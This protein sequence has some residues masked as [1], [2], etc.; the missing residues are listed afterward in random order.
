ME[1]LLRRELKSWQK[2][3]KVQHGREPTKRDIL[4]DPGIAGTYDTWM[5]VG[6][7]AKAAKSKSKPA[8]S[9]STDVASSSKERLD[10][11]PTD[12]RPRPSEESQRDQVFKTPSKKRSQ[13]FTDAT[14]PTTS[15]SRNPFRTPTKPSSSTQNSERMS[16]VAV[17]ASRKAR[18]PFA[19][20]SKASATPRSQPS[21]AGSLIEV[22]MTPTRR[23]PLDTFNR[24]NHLTPSES[25]SPH[26]QYVTSSPSKLR[27]AL[28]STEG[29]LRRTPTKNRAQS[30]AALKDALVAYTPRTKA[31]KRLRGEDVPPTPNRRRVSGGMVTSTEPRAVQRGLFGFAS[32]RKLAENSSITAPASVFARRSLGNAQDRVNSSTTGSEDEQDGDESIQSPIK[33]VRKFRRTASTAKVGFRPLFASPSANHSPKDVLGTMPPATGLSNSI[34]AACEVEKEE[35]ADALMDDD[36]GYRVGGL[37][38]AEVQQRRIRRAHEN[39]DEASVKKVKIRDAPVLPSSSDDEGVIMSPASYTCSP[40]Y[41]IGNGMGHSSPNTEMTIPSSAARS[42]H[43]KQ[44]EDASSPIRSTEGEKRRLGQNHFAG[45]TGSDWRKVQEVELSD[46]DEPK[47]NQNAL[48]GGKNVKKKVISMTPY[49]RDDDDDWQNEVDQDFTFLDSEIELQD[50]A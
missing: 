49:Q 13:R 34:N 27:G 41:C 26:S 38:A 31:R 28:I 11:A 1:Q 33:A 3:F 39:S 15:P 50:V 35:D 9:K 24:R 36:N 5:A 44:V 2:K 21:P 10:Q 19:T 37:F 46:E 25:P 40:A 47:A 7:D 16:A 12:P 18:N 14:V 48:Q 23:S 8:L 29:G 30:D 43:A 45:S 22:E 6:G 20:P 4:A 32:H 17:V 42:R